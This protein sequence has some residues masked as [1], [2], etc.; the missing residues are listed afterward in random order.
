MS[1]GRVSEAAAAEIETQTC[2]PVAVVDA[3][4][5]SEA[6]VAAGAAAVSVVDDD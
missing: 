4:V 5:K 1:R 2:R 6:G 3:G